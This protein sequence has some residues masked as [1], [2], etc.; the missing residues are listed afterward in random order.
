[1]KLTD[2]DQDYYTRCIEL[3]NIINGTPF[4][5]TLNDLRDQ[6]IT[7]M[8]RLN[9]V[10]DIQREQ[11]KLQILNQLINYKGVLSRDIQRIESEMN[12]EAT[13]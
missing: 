13:R 3:F 12:E 8:A 2:A 4:M 10:A 1:M 7:R 5:D 6:T 9:E 11:G